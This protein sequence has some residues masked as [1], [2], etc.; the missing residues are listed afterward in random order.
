M[1]GHKLEVAG[2]VV[3][4]VVALLQ[5]VAVWDLAKAVSQGSL[6]VEPEVA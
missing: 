4:K 6:V 3:E 1:D 5:A 2:R